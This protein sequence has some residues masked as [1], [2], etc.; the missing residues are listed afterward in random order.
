MRTRKLAALAASSA[1]VFGAPFA[2]TASA[3]HPPCG[4]TKPKHTNCGK[5]NGA[6]RGKKNGHSK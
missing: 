6:S 5:H 2:T 4:K 3:K 1:L